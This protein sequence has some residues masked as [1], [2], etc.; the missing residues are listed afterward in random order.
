MG[1]STTSLIGSPLIRSPQLKQKLLAL[2][3]RAEE[4]KFADMLCGEGKSKDGTSAP[5]LDFAKVQ[6]FYIT[7]VVMIAYTGLIWTKFSGTTAQIA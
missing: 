5:T 4:A 2:N 6:M 7:I 1:I 3:T